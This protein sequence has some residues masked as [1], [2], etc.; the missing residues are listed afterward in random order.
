MSSLASGAFIKM[1]N[2]V[3]EQY[4]EALKTLRRQKDVR[5]LMR[6]V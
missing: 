4:M 1:D 2:S 6:R 3:N 5:A